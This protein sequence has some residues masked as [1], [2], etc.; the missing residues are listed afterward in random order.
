M[1]FP[2]LPSF[3]FFVEIKFSVGTIRERLR[4]LG[5]TLDIHPGDNGTTVEARLPVAI[6][7]TVAA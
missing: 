7:S 1:R 3:T 4:Q 5:G 6:S 2:Q